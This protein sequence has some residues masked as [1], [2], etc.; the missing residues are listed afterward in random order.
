MP[1]I[2]DKKH[3]IAEWTACNVGD[4][5][6][7]DSADY[8]ATGNWSGVPD[9]FK[10]MALCRKNLRFGLRDHYATDNTHHDTAKEHTGLF[11]VNMYRLHTLVAHPL[12]PDRKPANGQELAVETLKYV[13]ET[14]SVPRGQNMPEDCIEE[15]VTKK[16]CDRKYDYWR[17]V[18]EP[19][20]GEWHGG[21]LRKTWKATK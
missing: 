15:T 4:R 19:G 3:E 21:R 7:S 12:M 16:L 1:A 20:Y 13:D 8:Y 5:W 2:S 14:A 11:L 18:P 10:F 17:N 9:A 6:G